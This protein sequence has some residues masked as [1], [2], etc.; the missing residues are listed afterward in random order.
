MVTDNSISRRYC[1]LELS[2]SLNPA[3]LRLNASMVAFSTHSLTTFR[4]SPLFHLDLGSTPPT[5]HHE[6][7]PF[8]SCIYIG[9]DGYAYRIGLDS[10]NSAQILLH[11]G[12]VII[13]WVSISLPLLFRDSPNVR[14]TKR[15]T[16][17]DLNYSARFLPMRS[18]PAHTRESSM[19]R[20]YI[21]HAGISGAWRAQPYIT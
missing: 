12:G 2:S 5:S 14:Y 11:L 4:L 3:S 8:T 20:M 7:L 15:S 16:M 17:Q 21:R 1:G 10:L 13:L 18:K 19:K 6:Y 9:A